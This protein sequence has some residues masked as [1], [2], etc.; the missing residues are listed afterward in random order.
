MPYAY[1]F[2]FFPMFNRFFSD[3][4]GG[5]NK[6]DE[7]RIAALVGTGTYLVAIVVLALLLLIVA[8]CSYKLNIAAKTNGYAVTANTACQLL[9]IG[10]YKLFNV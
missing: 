4:F 10:T 6:Q 8:R 1:P 9:V 5:F 7:A 3:L 2:A